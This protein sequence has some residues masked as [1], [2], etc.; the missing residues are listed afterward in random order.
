[1]K[2]NCGLRNQFLKGVLEIA[3]GGVESH[4]GQSASGSFCIL[5]WSRH[6]RVE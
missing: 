6:T 1:M 3:S 5:A 2:G 4:N